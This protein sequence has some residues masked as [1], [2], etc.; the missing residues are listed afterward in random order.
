[1]PTALCQS[2][3]LALA[4][5]PIPFSSAAANYHSKRMAFTTERSSGT[6]TVS[7]K[8]EG[9][10]SALVVISHGLGDTAEGFVDVAENLATAMPHVKF[11]LPTA[12]TQKVTMNMGMA[13]PSWYDI[14]GLD[15]RSNEN[16]AGIENSRDTIVGILEGEHQSTNLPYSRMVL[17]GFSQ[18]G[19][20]S[21]WCGLQLPQKLAG[22]VMMS[23]YLPAAK[24]FAITSGLEDTPVLH[25]HGD[26]DPL[27]RL[28]MAMKT[29][30]ILT[31]SKGATSYEL[32]TYPGLQHSVNMQELADVKKFLEKILPPDDSCKI[33]LKDPAEMSVKEL[34]AA[35]RKAGISGK[36]RGLMEKHEFVK[37]VQDHRNGK[38]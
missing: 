34:K 31:R 25:C 37:L 18:G 9:D 24:N 16:C 17:A 1:M 6:I 27:V 36:A 13:M 30:E 10:Q 7:P 3:L 26:A 32:K 38:L 28:E 21:L 20:L 15:E 35:I 12:P 8:N 29:K 14:T 2:L 19:A 23:A 5:R 22:I 11:I 4:F 33:Q